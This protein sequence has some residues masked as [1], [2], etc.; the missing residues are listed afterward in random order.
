MFRC[1]L[2]GLVLTV[3]ASSTLAQKQKIVAEATI[4]YDVV[5][6]KDDSSETSLNTQRILYIKG[7]QA[8]SDLRTASFV[9]T[10]ISDNLNNTAIVLKEIGENKYLQELT[11][12]QWREQN[13]AFEDAV[14]EKTNETKSVLGYTCSKIRVTY[15]DSSQ[16]VFYCALGL[17]ASAY[18]NP[19]QFKDLPGLV[20]AFEAP[21]Q[22]SK[23]IIRYT[24]VSMNLNPVPSVKFLKPKSGYRVL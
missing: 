6:I 8:R 23:E 4:V 13:R 21:V 11:A 2:I 19:F 9:Q 7:K 17:T 14:I 3:F 10:I 5:K 16:S 18:D 12:L 20:L 1:L 22:R 15:K 24:A